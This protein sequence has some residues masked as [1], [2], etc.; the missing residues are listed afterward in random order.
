MQTPKKI[1]IIGT[2]L[3]GGSL[4]LRLRDLKMASAIYGVEANPVHAATAV[5]TGLV[6]EVLPL[7]EAIR[8]A[9]VVVLSIPVDAAVSLLPDIL[10]LV[11]HQIVFD[12]GST[13]FQIVDCVK[14]H[15]HRNRFVATH[16]MWGTEKSGPTAALPDAFKQKAVVVCDQESSGTDALEWVEQLYQSMGMHLLY[17]SATDHDLHAA[18]VSHISHI[19]SFALANTVLAKEKEGSA[20]FEMAS[21]G[22]ESTVRLAKSNAAMWVPIF[23]Q[24]K[25]RVLDVLDEHIDQLTHFRQQLLANDGKGMEQFIQA[26]NQIARVL[27]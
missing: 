20:I 5:Q 19:T 3:I 21:G 22:F 10:N 13:K 18:Y 7:E 17:M 14:N 6:D 2:G 25:T 9:E 27:K 12:V 15:P 11:S 8:A 4:A 16:P 26:A 24:N 23:L 1:A